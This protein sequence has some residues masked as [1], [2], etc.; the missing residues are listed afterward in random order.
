M[1]YWPLFLFLFTC[2]M[3]AQNNA[4]EIRT[5]QIIRN[6]IRHKAQNNP[7]EKLSSFSFKSYTKLI[8]TAD[9]DSIRGELDTVVKRKF[10]GLGKRYKKVDSTQYKFKKY[11]CRQHFFET[12]KVSQ[13]QFDG[14]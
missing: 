4:G 5:N 2:A 7:Q 6:A 12:E 3:Q 14:N 8:V 13:Y 1:K 10:L 9:P 11:I